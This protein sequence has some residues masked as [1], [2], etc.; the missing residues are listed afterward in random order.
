MNLS[1]RRAPAPARLWPVCCAGLALVWWLGG[2]ASGVP[3]AERAALAAGLSLPPPPPPLQPVLA[4]SRDVLQCAEL[5]LPVSVQHN[6]VRLTFADLEQEMLATPAASGSLYVS[7]QPA[8]GG[9]SSPDYVWFKGPRATVQWQGQRLPECVVVPTAAAQYRA[10]GQEPSWNLNISAMGWTLQ[11]L[12]GPGASWT[13]QGAPQW[14]GSNRETTRLHTLQPQGATVRITER[15]CAD[16]MTGMPYPQTVEVMP[17]PGATPLRGCGGQP[18]TLLQDLEW[19][20]V[21]VEP[22]SVAPDLWLQDPPATVLMDSQGALTGR[23]PCNRYAGSYTL[24]GEGLQVQQPALTRMACAPH[25]MAMERDF[26]AVLNAVHRFERPSANE[27][28]FHAPNGGRVVA[29]RP[30]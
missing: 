21:G 28:V 16:T 20:V 5:L 8:P 27:I 17:E 29:R 6:V 2:C 3:A 10:V 25:R 15:L 23:A 1:T 24:S 11:Q 7:A 9:A 22:S 14:S 26:M 18:A 30:D 4:A 19:R 13:P 12:G